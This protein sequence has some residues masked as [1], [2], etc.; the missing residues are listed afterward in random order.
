VIEAAAVEFNTDAWK[1]I[2][3]RPFEIAGRKAFQETWR[4]RIA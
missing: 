2:A 3:V 1:L 4:H